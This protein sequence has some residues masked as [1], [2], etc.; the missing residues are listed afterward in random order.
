MRIVHI[1][2]TVAT[3]RLAPGVHHDLTLARRATATGLEVD[4]TAELLYRDW[5]HIE[6][7]AGNRSGLNTAIT[8][9]DQ[10]NRSLNL[11]MEPATEQLMR[12]LL[13]QTSP[14]LQP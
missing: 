13:D 3:H 8:R 11:P 2:H 4:D 5:F 10:V 6:A 12:Q 9:L 14:T 7:A 1:A